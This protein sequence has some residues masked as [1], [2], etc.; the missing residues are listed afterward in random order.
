MN[1]FSFLISGWQAL[2]RP[3]SSIIDIEERRQS[4]LLAG[5]IVSLVFTSMIAS[6]LLLW[7]SGSLSSTIAGVWFSMAFIVAVYFI[8]RGGRYRLS[9][10]IFVGFTLAVTCIMPILTNELGWLF[11]TN[12]V[13]LL[14]AML[15]PGLTT[16]IFFVCLF[17]QAGLAIFFPLNTTMSNVSA[18]VVYSII[19]PLVV[20]FVRQRIQLEKERRQELQSINESLR[21]SEMQLESRVAGR[22]AELQS[23]NQKLQEHL[24]HINNLRKKLREESIR[25]PLTGLFN[26]RYLEEILSREFARARRGDYDISFMLLDIDH[27]KEFN[28]RHGHATGDTALRALAS[29]L[30]SRIRAADIPCRI[31]GEEFLL[32]LP[33]ILD[34]VA[35]LR[36]EYFRD[37]VQSMLI[38]C[39]EENLTLTVSI[40]IAS[41]PKNGENWEAIYQA[42]DQ[43]LYR[44]KQNGRNRVECA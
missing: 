9:A 23:A 16:T 15:L 38:P 39:G 11:F 34:E 4:Q 27:F 35:Q 33:G 40:G 22:T 26:R 17:F 43:A 1:V 32:V 21:R 12:M 42:M 13:L 24:E 2:T 18:M 44:A 25:D 37:Q 36:A 28:D 14:S 30:N 3:H 20:V 19:G 31:G 8:N 29:R 41:Y 7:R 10:S 6:G 5:L